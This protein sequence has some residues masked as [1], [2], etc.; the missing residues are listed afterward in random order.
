L[1]IPT[2]QGLLGE[3]DEFFTCGDAEDS[4]IFV[5]SAIL[6]FDCTRVPKRSKKR[7]VKQINYE[8]RNK[9]QS[10]KRFNQRRAFGRGDANELETTY[11]V[12]PKSTGK[13]LSEKS[14]FPLCS[15]DLV[16]EAAAHLLPGIPVHWIKEGKGGIT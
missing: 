4:M 13:S 10:A 6:Q 5:L 12:S 16:V 11:E 7:S 1:E 8:R 3:G 9:D 15:A 14:R 2:I